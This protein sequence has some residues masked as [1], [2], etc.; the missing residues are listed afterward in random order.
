[1][2]RGVIFDLDGTLL[3]P[4]IDFRALRKEI[5]APE[6]CDLIEYLKTLPPRRRFEAQAI[7]EAHE[8]GAAE[9]AEW[10]Q[11]AKDVLAFLQG[12]GMPFA[13]CTRNSRASLEHV[14][15][16]LGLAFACAV[17]RDDTSPKPSPEPVLR[18]AEILDL[19]VSAVL[20]VGDF[21]FDMESALRAGAYAAFLTNG[22]SP[23]MATRAHF[24]VQSLSELIPLMEGLRNGSIVPGPPVTVE[25]CRS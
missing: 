12:L 19:P 7:I 20:V 3:K 9:S 5:G 22:R 25:A 4:A 16:R 17:C 21:A 1:M 2:I 6:A 15:N 10:N 18:V 8:K 23:W 13:V 24:V 11:G 14:Q